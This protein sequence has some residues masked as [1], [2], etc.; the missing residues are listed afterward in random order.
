VKSRYSYFATAMLACLWASYFVSWW[1]KGQVRDA[2]AGRRYPQLLYGARLPISAETTSPADASQLGRMRRHL[3][4]A[5]EDACPFCRRNRVNWERLLS[6]S[7]WPR[8][9]DVWLIPV[10]GAIGSYSDLV[11]LA[12]EHSVPLRVLSVR[13]RW[14]FTVRT[15]LVAVPATVVVDGAERIRLVRTGEM[16]DSDVFVFTAALRSD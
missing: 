10:T 12:K 14:V 16:A 3:V 6:M 4:L 11:T 2:M 7:A 5:F 9:T 8:D 15:G 13:R 1:A